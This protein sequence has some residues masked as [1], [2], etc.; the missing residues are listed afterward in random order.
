MENPM[1]K[2]KKAYVSIYC[3]IYAEN[4]SNEMIGQKATGTEIYNFLMKD[5]GLYA[6]KNDQPLPGDANIWYLGSNEK[7]GSLVYNDR[8]WNWGYGESSFDIVAD[9]IRAIHEDGLFTEE[10]YQNLMGKIKEGRKIKDMY[11]IG[12]HLYR[13]KNEQHRKEKMNHAI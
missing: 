3:K 7:F 1:N 9:F 10:Q 4:F 2:E 5:A 11:A 13:I 12:N 6:D 8:I